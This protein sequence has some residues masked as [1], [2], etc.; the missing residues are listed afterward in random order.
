MQTVWPL[1][2][3][4]GY[5][6]SLSTRM[7]EY[8]LVAEPVHLGPNGVP[9]KNVVLFLATVLST[10][11]AGTLWY[12]VN[13]VSNPVGAVMTAWPF[14]FAVMGVLGTHEL[15][16]YVMS[17]YHGVEA[18]LPY[19]IPV[20]LS[21]IGTM[22]AVI[23]MKGQMPNRKAL[24]DIGVAGPIA[25]LVATVVVTAVG[26]TLDPVT[27]PQ[28]VIN[29]ANTMEVQFGYPPL[30]KGIA[31]VMGQPLT[32]ADPS[33]SVNPVVIGGWVGMFVTFLNLIPVGQ[34]DGGHIVRAMIGERQ[35]SIAALVP[36]MLFGLAAYV[37]YVLDV[38]NA[39]VLWV[40]WGFLSMFFAYVGPAN[41][42][43]EDGLDAKRMAIGILTFIVGVLCFT[44]VPI[45]IIGP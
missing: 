12:H 42:V 31:A 9:W 20:P 15:G 21:I 22:G 23:R 28:S 38:S 5:E 1:F 32:F 19:F 43:N 25:G 33:R 10:L 13:P 4:Q 29:S 17:R 34:L 7:G 18:S 41:P 3:E 36:A 35:E 16:H 11:W 8:V 26:L 24:F 2:R 27:V 14:T 6:V 39:T 45:E 30:L 44:P 40:I 37:F